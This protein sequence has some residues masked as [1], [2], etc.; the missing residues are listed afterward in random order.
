LDCSELL[1]ELIRIAQLLNQRVR[2]NEKCPDAGHDKSIRQLY[3]K[4]R[5]IREQYEHHCGPPPPQVPVLLVQVLARA[6]G[7]AIALDK[8]ITGPHPFPFGS[9]ATLTPGMLGEPWPGTARWVAPLPVPQP[10][11]VPVP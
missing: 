11:L 3:N 2:A 10:I 9:G 7:T 6:L 8:L 4:Y 1:A 5:A